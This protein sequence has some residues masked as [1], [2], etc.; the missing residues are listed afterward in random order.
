MNRRFDRCEPTDVMPLSPAAP[1][2]LALPTATPHAPRARLRFA[3]SSCERMSPPAHDLR[4]RSTAEVP[5][6][7][8]AHRGEQ[9]NT[10]WPSRLHVPAA[11]N[12]HLGRREPT[13]LGCHPR[14]TSLAR[15][16]DE[17]TESDSF[18]ETRR[19]R[20]AADQE[21][22][23]PGSRPSVPS[24]DRERPPSSAELRPA[25]CRSKTNS[26]ARAGDGATDPARSETHKQT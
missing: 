1:H 8:T 14:T 3:R 11:A 24:S 2:R 19:N 9:R 17:A 20:C 15:A 16:G 5:H 23:P 12:D 13:G 21:V 22:E 26:L 25:G 18:R 4:C 10:P 7:N 6:A